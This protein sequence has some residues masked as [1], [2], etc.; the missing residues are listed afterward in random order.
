MQQLWWGDLVPN[1]NWKQWEFFMGDKWREYKLL[2]LHLTWG[3]RGVV[4]KPASGTCRTSRLE[5]QVWTPVNCL[6]P[7]VWL[8]FTIF[9][10]SW[11]IF[12]SFLGIFV[13]IVICRLQTTQVFSWWLKM[14]SPDSQKYCMTLKGNWEAFSFIKVISCL[15][16]SLFFCDIVSICTWFK[17]KKGNPDLQLRGSTNWNCEFLSFCEMMWLPVLAALQTMLSR[18]PGQGREG[19]TSV[20]VCLWAGIAVAL[21]LFTS[22]EGRHRCLY[23]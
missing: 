3:Q 23:S 17:K 11:E 20:A 18:K 2:L 19:Q 1:K 4:Q 6:W 10:C 8:A 14:W 7:W 5:G 22:R 13:I 15:E 9:T 21:H 16:N 12:A